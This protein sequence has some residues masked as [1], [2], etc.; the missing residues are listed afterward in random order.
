M[1]FHSVVNSDMISDCRLHAV[2]CTSKMVIPVLFVQIHK[3][4]LAF[5]LAPFKVGSR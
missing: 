3:F 1:L 2:D 4:I 5:I